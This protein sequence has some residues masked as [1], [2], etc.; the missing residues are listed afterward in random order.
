MPHL[1]ANVANQMVNLRY[2]AGE[3]ILDDLRAFDNNRSRNYPPVI[4]T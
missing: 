4:L 1:A 3:I 2:P